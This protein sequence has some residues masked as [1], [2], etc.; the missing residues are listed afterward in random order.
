MMVF[1][2]YFFEMFQLLVSYFIVGM[3]YTG[4]FIGSM[5]DFLPLI[6]VGSN[7]ALIYYIGVIVRNYYI[8]KY[9]EQFRITLEYE[10]DEW[11]DPK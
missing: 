1:R 4:L 10:K 11:F 7:F 2:L 8:L 5:A 9:S 3:I 6:S